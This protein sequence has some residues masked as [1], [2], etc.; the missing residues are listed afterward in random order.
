M[1]RTQKKSQAHIFG[2]C[3][4]RNSRHPGDG[5]RWWR[6]MYM[7]TVLAETLNPKSCEFSLNASLTPKPIFCGHPP[8]ERLKL[9]GESA[10]YHSFGAADLIAKT[11]KHANP[12]DAT[13]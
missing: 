1:V 10:V 3:R 12:V 8:D 7:A 9:M 5:P 2:S 11:N 6:L 4:F 13:S